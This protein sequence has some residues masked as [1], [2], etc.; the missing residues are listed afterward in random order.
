MGSA[1][2]IHGGTISTPAPL[3]GQTF[4]IDLSSNWTTD[5]PLYTQ[6]STGFADYKFPNTLMKGNSSWFTVSNHTAYQY[7][8][9]NNTWNEIGVSGNAN[10]MSGISAAMDPSSGLVYV[11]NGWI[12]N[13]TVS[14]QIYNPENNQLSNVAV[15]PSLTGASSFATL[16]SPTRN[17]LLVHG[18]VVSGSM[19]RSLYEYIPEVGWTLLSDQGDVPSARKSHCMVNAYGGTKIIVFGGIDQ[20]GA[21][22]GDIYSLDTKTL[23]WTKGT[24][25]GALIARGEAACAITNDLMVVWGG[26][27]SNIVAKSSNIT[28]VYN[29]KQNIWQR[30]YTPLPD[31]G[32]STAPSPDGSSSK[33]NIGAIVGG[34]IGGLAVIAFAAG[35][36]IYRRKHR[37]HKAVI[38]TEGG[39]FVSTDAISPTQTYQMENISPNQQQQ[40]PYQK[41][42]QPDINNDTRTQRPTEVV[43]RAPQTLPEWNG[44]NG[45]SEG[46]RNPHI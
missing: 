1:M 4:S 6:L 23:I 31:P 8:I 12:V 37:Y 45:A 28:A 13:T 11:A 3:S 27:N 18:G 15:P 33:S 38:N 14:M 22:L 9:A 35:F 10:P 29:M 39:A 24:T 19:L 40:Q 7:L 2:Y 32:P 25:G 46:A 42:P 17:S 44:F 5:A 36:L 43:N 16:W 21:V 34:T 41:Y 20:N 30:T 26:C